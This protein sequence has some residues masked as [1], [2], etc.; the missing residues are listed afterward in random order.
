MTEARRRPSTRRPNEGGVIDAVRAG[1]LA[2]EMGLRVGDRITAIDGRVLRDAVDF[3]FY[4]AE[5][6]I[7]L[8]VVRGGASAL[9]GSNTPGAI[10]NYINKT[11]GDHFAGTMRATA[12]TEALGRYD[13]NIG[14]PLGN[15]W[16]FNAGG[17]Y[18][19]GVQVGDRHFLVDDERRLPV[20]EAVG[21]RLPASSLHLYSVDRHD[22][23]T[24]SPSGS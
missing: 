8:E 20:Q 16:H 24:P 7:E 4:A 3:Q 12:G 14:G 10:V 18:R 22:P 6:I 15:D 2:D 21:I 17:F 5:D 11:G 9:F 19:Y 23:L 13:L 1:S